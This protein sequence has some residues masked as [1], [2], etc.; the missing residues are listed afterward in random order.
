MDC[1]KGRYGKAGAVL[2]LCEH[3]KFSLDRGHYSP[4]I[5]S[6]ESQL[7]QGVLYLIVTLR[8]GENPGEKYYYWHNHLAYCNF[9]LD[10]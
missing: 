2:L 4:Q 7:C 3:F 6:L 10:C 9:P 8:I 1:T 5:G